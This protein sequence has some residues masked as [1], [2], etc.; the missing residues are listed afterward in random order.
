MRNRWGAGGVSRSSRG[1]IQHMGGTRRY[2]RSSTSVS[3]SEARKYEDA[4]DTREREE[5]V[6]DENKNVGGGVK[7]ST[8]MSGTEEDVDEGMI[9]TT[10]DGSVVRRNIGCAVEGSWDEEGL[11]KRDGQRQGLTSQLSWR[12]RR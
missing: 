6:E 5:D 3:S 7:F 9:S 12:T 8:M 2:S 10:V 4:E 1:A 11:G